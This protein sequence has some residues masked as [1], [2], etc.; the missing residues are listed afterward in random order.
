MTRPRSTDRRRRTI[1]QI[2]RAERT[3]DE[4]LEALVCV[5]FSN[6]QTFFTARPAT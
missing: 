3:A 1:R 2:V 5:S 6:I 4:V